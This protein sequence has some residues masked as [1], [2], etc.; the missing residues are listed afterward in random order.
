M[1]IYPVIGLAILVLSFGTQFVRI[2]RVKRVDGISPWAIGEL[3][4]CCLLFA[5][6]YLGNGHFLALGLNSLL[7]LF[8]VGILILYLKYRRVHKLPLP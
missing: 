8:A 3:I 7:F 6:Y 5:G 4:V 1:E 2:W